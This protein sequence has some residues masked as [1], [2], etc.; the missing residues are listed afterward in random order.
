MEVY[1][2]ARFD[3]SSF[4]DNVFTPSLGF[5]YN[6]E[7]F[8]AKLLYSEAYRAPEHW[9]YS[10]GLGNSNL[11]PEEIR[12]Y[13]AAANFRA[14]DKI[15]FGAALY[16]N[17]YFNLLK[18]FEDN[19]GQKFINSGKTNTLGSEITFDYKSSSIKAF[20]NYTYNISEDE[21]GSE[22]PEISKH[23]ANAGITYFPVEEI[24]ISLRG[25]FL[26]KRRNNFVIPTT[27]NNLIDEALIL[28]SSIAYTGIEHIRLSF[29]VNNILDEK[30]FHTSNRPPARYGQPQRTLFFK[31][32][33][34]I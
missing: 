5:V 20:A 21:S 17:K 18:L 8:T 16:H 11:K 14:T 3:H 4:Y 12:S 28:N 2:G 23:V 29:L 34:N 9:D 31:L 10:F 27:G 19:N 1:L 30:Y 33:F 26:G 7:K 13:E 6:K 32:E 24:G 15:T 25:T 22:L